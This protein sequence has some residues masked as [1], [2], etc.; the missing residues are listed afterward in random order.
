MQRFKDLGKHLWHCGDLLMRWRARIGWLCGDGGKYK[1]YTVNVG[2]REF[3][4][5]FFL[6][7]I[8]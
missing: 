7:G 3:L 2:E 5:F 4:N 8:K 1:F 6:L